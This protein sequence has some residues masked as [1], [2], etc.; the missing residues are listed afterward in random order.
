[1]HTL[2][3]PSNGKKTNCSAFKFYWDRVESF[4][5]P[6]FFQAADNF[7]SAQSRKKGTLETVD[8]LK[9]Y[10]KYENSWR[11]VFLLAL[12]NTG[13]LAVFG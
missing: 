1:M 11:P 10:S 12:G 3:E 7:F 9:F 13:N 5:N 8:I 4:H 2:E 6:C